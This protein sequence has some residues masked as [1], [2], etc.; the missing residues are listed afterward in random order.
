M[1]NSNNTNSVIDNSLLILQFNANGLKYHSLERETVLNNKS[2]DIAL[3]TETHFTKY[4]YI[5]IPG[6][7]L[8]KTNHPD[9]TMHE[10]V[11]IF[12]KST[13]T[14]DPLPNFCQDFLQS[15]ALSIIVNNTSLTVAAIYSPP[16]HNVTNTQFT[17]TLLKIILL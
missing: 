4:S 10:G 17:L 2:I 1:P 16:K 11:A 5:R 15:C 13:F 12:V 6:F 14:F 7:T 3:T 8:I 9:N